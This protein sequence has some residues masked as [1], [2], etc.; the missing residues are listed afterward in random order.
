MLDQNPSNTL[1]IHFVIDDWDVMFN[2]AKQK[3]VLTETPVSLFPTLTECETPN[4]QNLVKSKPHIYRSNSYDPS[5]KYSMS[6]RKKAAEIRQFPSIRF[7]DDA[8]NLVSPDTE[9]S[10]SGPKRSCLFKRRTFDLFEKDEE[11]KQP[12][13]VRQRSM[14]V[15]RNRSYTLD[16]DFILDQHRMHNQTDLEGITYLK[17]NGKKTKYSLDASSSETE[18]VRNNLLWMTEEEYDIVLNQC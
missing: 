10:V 18:R 3:K 5:K 6:Y 17:H 16:K 13:M 11:T 8:E 4:K 15:S 14:P 2:E 7:Y 12:L 9:T 1:H